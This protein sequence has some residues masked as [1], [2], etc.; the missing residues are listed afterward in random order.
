MTYENKELGLVVAENED[1]KFYMDI[2]KDCKL[3][4]AN[5]EKQLRFNKDIQEM[6]EHKLEGLNGSV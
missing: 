3:N 1:E 6:A 4:I 2:V 5:I